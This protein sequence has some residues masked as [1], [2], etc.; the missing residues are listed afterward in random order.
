MAATLPGSVGWPITGDRTI[1]F[2]R[3]PDE[4]VQ[5][6]VKKCSSKIFQTR[7]LNKPHVFVTSSQGVKELLEGTLYSKIYTGVMELEARGLS[8]PPLPNNFFF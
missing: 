7:M 5:S 1:E 8:P 2:T 3:N 4:F 6:C